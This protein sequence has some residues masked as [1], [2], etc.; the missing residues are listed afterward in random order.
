MALIRFPYQSINYLMKNI[1]SVIL[2]A[3]FAIHSFGQDA[4]EKYI[5]SLLNTKELDEVVTTASRFAELKRNVAQQTI[6]ITSKKLEEFNAQNTAD[7]LQMSGMVGVQKSQQNGGS[8]QIRGFEA[9]RVLMVVDGVR[10]NNAIY[11]AG[12][13]QNALRIDNNVLDRIEV[14]FGPSSTV[15]GSDALG[16]VVHF[17]T[18]DPKLAKEKNFLARGSV[19]GRFG[20]VNNEGTGHF[21][22]SLANQKFGSLTSVTFSRFGDLKAGENGNQETDTLWNLNRYVKRNFDNTKDTIVTNNDPSLQKR[23]GYIQYDI[24]QKFLYKQ[25][26]KIV[27]VLNLQFSN[28]GNTPRYDR[29]TT[30]AI[31]EWYYGPETR[32]LAAYEFRYRNPGGALDEITVGLNYQYIRESRH[33]RNFNAAFR[34]DRVETLN[35]PAF[36]ANFKKKLTAVNELYFGT[37]GQFNILQST[38]QRYNILA[39]TTA[40]QSTRYPDG[41]NNMNNI[42]VYATHSYYYKDLIVFSQG[43]RYNYTGLHGEFVDTNFYKLNVGKVTQVNHTA[44]GNLGLVIKPGAGLKIALLGS[45]GFRAPNFDDLAKVFESVK[46]NVIVPN[47]NL[48]PEYTVNGDLTI[49]ENWENK[50]KLSVTGYYTEMFNAIVTETGTY[51]G[52]DSILYDGVLSRVVSNVNKRR[53]FIAG[54]SGTMDIRPIEFFHV[55]GSVNFTYARIRDNLKT[56]LD[57]IPPL[58]GR[59]GAGGNYKGFSADVFAMFSA[60]KRL[61]DYSPEGEDNLSQATPNG[62]PAWVTLNIRVSQRLFKDHLGIDLGVNN[63]MDTKYRTFSSGLTAPGRNIFVALRGYF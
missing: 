30:P 2:F 5:D 38:A 20:T 29:L 43:V 58:Y 36:F 17:R 48:K 18:K 55:Y 25:N 51:G 4:E 52:S 8:L 46:G 15:Y 24:L 33:N 16:G 22:V 31:A 59:F 44:S 3:A 47:K 56:P 23:T 26:D 27:H 6:V 9:S 32:T 13:L 37:E 62:M 41:K 19:M 34:T 21:D 45:S 28:T 12:H 39:D 10:M 60:R 49:E 57:H 61:E 42:A 53:A 7:A 50:V 40:P 11:R 63:I 1:L 35:I 54:L 14:L